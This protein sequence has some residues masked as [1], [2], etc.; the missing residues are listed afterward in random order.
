MQ[1]L[2]GV[3]MSIFLLDPAAGCLR[4]Q[5]E[6]AENQ[7]TADELASISEADY[8]QRLRGKSWNF[9]FLEFPIGAFNGPLATD[10]EYQVYKDCGFN[11]VITPRYAHYKGYDKVTAALDLAQKH[12]LA[13]L[14]ETY[15]HHT[16]AWGGLDG[17]YNRRTHHPATLPELKWIHERW[18]KHPAL[19]GYMLADDV[20]SLP[21]PVVD[22]TA[23]LRETAPHLWPW[24]CQLTLRT[25][26]LA[27]AGNPLVIPQLYATLHKSHY[28]PPN[29]M[30]YFCRQ[31]NSLREN[32][33]SQGLL[34]M[35]MFNVSTW[36][37]PI[38]SDSIVRF[39][40]YASIAYGAQ[41]IWY[42]T[43]RD[44]GSLVSGKPKDDTVE[45]I[46]AICDPKWHV[47]KEA[48]HRVAVWG[49]ELRWREVSEIFHTGWQTK[50]PGE[51]QP[52]AGKLIVSM[53][54]D[55]LAGIPRKDGAPPLAMVVDKR[56]DDGYKTI[57][58]REVE[59]VFSDTV[60]SI[61]I[62]NLDA[63]KTVKGNRVKLTIQSG[64]GQL[65]R[66]NET[67]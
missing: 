18:G 20:G 44:F 9:K 17:P 41:G 52:G 53:S 47:A 8:M 66:L 23:W 3:A 28:P 12:K 11:V 7:R 6:S 25:G 43:Y 46:Q 48:N 59:V 38:R 2:I 65:I 33:F 31:I 15:T 4:A 57:E 24:V 27:R 1:R 10:A 42:F 63:T 54:E 49:S 45:A 30:Q 35:P 5:Q 64:G 62:L 37:K 40:V 60:N 51:V 36:K 14:L 56:V 50:L 55:L 32:C 13:A 39:Q 26:S 19:I 67:K 21:G 29:R 34:P 22:T 16:R 58:P 61:D